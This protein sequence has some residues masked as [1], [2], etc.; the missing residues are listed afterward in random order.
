MS[1][2]GSPRFSRLGRALRSEEDA[3][4]PPVPVPD[5]G[6]FKRSFW[7]SPLR[8]PWL[9]SFL[10]S[11]L[12]PLI[13]ICAVTGFLSQ[14]AYDPRLGSNDLT[15][16]YERG[17][18]FFDWPAH[19]AWLY[20]LNQGLHVFSGIA[21]TPIL[22]AK[23][24][25][26]IPKLWERP[27]VRS[28]SHSL[29]RLS[30]AALVGGILFVLFTG[31][32]NI[33]YWYP[34]GEWSWLP[35]GGFGFLS[36][37]YYGAVV[38][39]AALALHVLLKVPTV[40]ATFREHG[41]IRPL[42]VPRAETRA[43]DPAESLSVPTDPDAPTVSRRGLIAVAGGTSLTLLLLGAGQ[44]IG[45]PLRSIALLAPRGRDYGDGPNDFQINT[46]A[47]AAG[48]DPARTGADWRLELRSPRLAAPVRISREEL[49]TLPQA[50]EKLPIACVEGWTTEQTWSGI[51]LRDLARIAGVEVPGQ[52]MVESLQEGGTLRKVTL[53]P[54]KV[55]QPRA[56]LALRVNG[57]DLSPDHGFP[58]RIVVPALPGVHNTK[59]VARM[60]FEDAA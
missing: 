10:S 16:G 30:L 43:S 7:R 45:G 27:A 36:G 35:G 13:L 38:F 12:L 54:N 46:T 11:A 57:A 31:I 29:E 44:S 23:L 49:L 24:W 15:G 33:Q 2:G 60:T 56:L 3:R 55:R 26:V 39:L 6:P 28:I 5:V 18:Y 59:W 41:V 51:R 32:V 47:A 19:P 22:L 42:R 21:A 40:A 25:A 34:W 17:L 9:V 52:L 48:I 50:T 53:S 37:H 14:A 58:A 4:R 8:D 20:G 1:E